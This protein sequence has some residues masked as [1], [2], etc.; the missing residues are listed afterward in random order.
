MSTLKTLL[1]GIFT[2]KKALALLAGAIVFALSKAGLNIL[3]SSITPLLALIGT[4]IVGQGIA[5][6]GKE[7]AK[8]LVDDSKKK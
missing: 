3:E 5:D 7:A 6:N 1:V 2:S 8:V 4:Y